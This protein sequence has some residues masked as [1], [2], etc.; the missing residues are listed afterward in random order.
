MIDINIEKSNNMGVE[1][2]DIY[3]WTE[4]SYKGDEQII[5]VY[6]I[7]KNKKD[8]IVFNNF[9]YSN[10]IN[11]ISIPIEKDYDTLKDFYTKNNISYKDKRIKELYYEDNIDI[12][13]G[14][15]EE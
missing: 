2:K 1:L 6:L 10:G 15:K 8:V 3:G 11:I 7:S 13:I 5:K 12:K 4:E 9:K 14:I